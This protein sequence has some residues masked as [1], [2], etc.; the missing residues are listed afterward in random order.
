MNK[1]LL[2]TAVVAGL[3]S[4]KLALADHHEGKG[5]DK[6]KK[7]HSSCKKGCNGSCKNKKKKDAKKEAAP[8][9]APEAAPAPAAPADG[10]H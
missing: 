4:G 1:K 2:M 10:N 3:I 7:E 6:T 9:P 5:D 8:A